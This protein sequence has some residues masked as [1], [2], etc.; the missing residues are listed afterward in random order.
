[1][2]KVCNYH[3][4]T[5]ITANLV[6]VGPVTTTGYEQ[7]HLHVVGSAVGLFYARFTYILALLL[8]SI[9][10]TYWGMF[11]RKWF[12]YLFAAAWIYIYIITPGSCGADHGAWRPL[13]NLTGDTAPPFTTLN[14]IFLRIYILL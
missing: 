12:A 9:A 6:W 10:Y 14:I 4:P 1:V 7:L 2:I 5:P 11:R 8:A 3:G 13:H